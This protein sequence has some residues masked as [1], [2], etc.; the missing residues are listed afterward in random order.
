MD[1]K[2]ALHSESSCSVSLVCISRSKCPK[3]FPLTQATHALLQRCNYNH[4]NKQAVH[5]IFLHMAILK[6][7]LSDHVLS[8]RIILPGAAIIEM[9]S[10]AVLRSVEMLG[11]GG[12]QL[13]NGPILE[14][15][16]I[17][18]P[19]VVENMMLPGSEGRDMTRLWCVV[20]DDGELSL[21]G[22]D[23]TGIRVV[24]ASCSVQAG[25]GGNDNGNGNGGGA[26]FEEAQVLAAAKSADEKCSVSVN[27]DEVYAEY[28]AGG[29][30]F[31]PCFRLLHSAKT[32]LGGSY[33]LC[34]V[35]VG[36]R[37]NWST[38]LLP[39]PLLDVMLQCTASL[40]WGN[41]RSAEAA[42]I[43]YA[44]D[45]LWIR[46]N[47]ADCSLWSSK[48]CTVFVETV[49]VESS[50]TVCNYALISDEGSVVV[51]AKG[52]HSRSMRADT[53]TQRDPS[54]TSEIV[55]RWQPWSS[56]KN[57]SMTQSQVSGKMEM[58]SCLVVGEGISPAMMSQLLDTHA[59]WMC[60]PR[61]QYLYLS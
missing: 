6:H 5:E 32:C 2:D 41:G 30:S 10:S 29:L 50:M 3:R 17:H 16:A 35:H 13:S 42:Q 27:V 19:V 1:R 7:W 25:N 45:G 44:V 33:A 28:E 22:E 47:V 53:P 9:M 36:D 24:H 52:V 14:G 15:L 4:F 12:A 60:H 55:P 58:S 43:P 59:G 48:L 20:Q 54:G 40:T 49:R 61:G 31:G 57:A 37:S 38:Y 11:I 39:P 56:E 51:Y 21:Y 34:R 46:P 8:G 18:R 26:L 23:E